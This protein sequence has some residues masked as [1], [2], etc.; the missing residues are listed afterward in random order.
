MALGWKGQYL[1]YKERF[2]NIVAIYGQKPDIKAFLE[3]LLSL[4]TISVFGIFALKPTLLT[5]SQL[6]TEVKGK[7]ETLT[8]MEQKITDLNQAQNIFFQETEKINLIKSAV[9]ENPDPQT[10]VRQIEGVASKNSVSILGISLGEVTLVGTEQTKAKSKESPLPPGASGLSY[11]IS[12]S[13]NY[14]NLFSFLSDLEN[15]RR[16]LKI[17]N[18]GIT[19]SETED[20]KTIIMIISGRAPY[21]AE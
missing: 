10:F 2:F 14:I 17:D 19:L 12:V 16:P 3:I 18:L 15:L 11:S 9:P 6:I 20:G 1:R 7:E 8:K 13:G 4:G 5:I 21:L